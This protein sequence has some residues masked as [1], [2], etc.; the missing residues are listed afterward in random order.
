MLNAGMIGQ[1]DL[2]TMPHNHLGAEKLLCEWLKL[3]CL[4]ISLFL[5]PQILVDIHMTILL[6]DE[7]QGDILTSELLQ[8]A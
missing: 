4:H 2:G 7:G 8:L 3:K 5:A 1:I 6:V